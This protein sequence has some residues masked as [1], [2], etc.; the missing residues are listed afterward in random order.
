MSDEVSPPLENRRKKLGLAL[1][2]GGARGLAHI[3]VLKVLDREQI[4]VDVIAGTSMGGIVGALYAA[5]FSG[6]R[7]EAEVLRISRSR[8]EL[9]KL[10]D[11]RLGAAGLLGGSRIT[12]MLTSL[13]GADLTFTDLR[14]PFAV[15]GVDMLS[16]REVDLSEGKV[17]EAVRATMSVPGVFTPV[18]IGPY[19]LMDGGIL[20]NVPVDV[21]LKLGA[22]VVIAVD[23]LPNFRLNQPGQSPVVEP[24]Q[25][26]GLPPQFSNLWHVVL[27]MMS[28]LTEYRLKETPPDLMIRPDVPKD[29]D[30]LFGFE[31]AAQAISAGEQ[32]AKIS[33]NDI[34]L[35]PGV[36]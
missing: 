14:I 11:L 10:I 3:G 25:S 7:I 17:V 13:L 1:G 2:G 27:V 16:G 34:R 6:E 32:A 5:G 30:I 18:E 21:A 12:E 29:I 36:G 20:N 9:V 22:D 24:I 26:H 35:L 8:L 19:R 33:L 28:A 15:T 23:V 4:T 31:Q